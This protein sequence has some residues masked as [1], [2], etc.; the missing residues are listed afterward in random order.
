M[1]QSTA[2]DEFLFR[3]GASA[4]FRR[5][6]VMPGIGQHIWLGREEVKPLSC[7]VEQTLQRRFFK[8]G[9]GVAT[10]VVHEASWCKLAF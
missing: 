5:I 7:C 10:S 1:L 3:Y 4:V 9:V 8:F 2:E 6:E